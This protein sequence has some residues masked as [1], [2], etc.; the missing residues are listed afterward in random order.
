MDKY[1]ISEPCECKREHRADIDE[2]IIGKG[3]VR[4]VGEVVKSY[5][6]SKPFVLADVNTFE[7]AGKEVCAVLEEK[8][9]PY[10][11]YV[12]ADEALKPDEKAVGSSVLH[13]DYSCD[14]IIAVG[15][16][17]IN[18][19]GKILSRISGRKYIIAATAPS[20]DGYASGTSSIDRDGFKLS[21][22]S[23]CADVIIGDVDILKNAPLHMLKS[24][25]GDM[26]A[27]YISIAE[28]RIGHLVTGEY[29]CER[30]A[31]LVRDALKKCTDNALGLLKRDD[32]AVEAVFE[33][34]V[35]S[36]LAMA[37][38]GISRPASGVEHYFSHVWDMR[39]LE[40]STS[41]DLHGIQCAMG[42][43]R[44][45]KLYESLKQITP[46][47]EKALKYVKNFDYDAWKIQLESFF[48]KGARAMIEQEKT[49][50][51]YS[52]AAHRKRLEKIIDNWDEILKIL[53]EELPSFEQLDELMTALDMPKEFMSIGVDEEAAKLTFLA[54]K[55]IRDKYILSRLA[56]DLG[57]IEELN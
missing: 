5:N 44:A 27:K 57:V 4:Q 19:I 29:Y 1:K 11:K 26:I 53:D 50:Q 34:L 18:D 24:G 31:Q 36:G 39:S 48:G 54:T 30:I 55:D 28:W 45:V 6:C 17:V 40:F 14:I 20:V 47:R 43:R 3:V 41:V 37:Y 10:V 42:S 46:D 38:A 23:R 22:D 15:S 8:G 52:K 7:A 9:I 32:A 2:I 35:I 51:K 13:F 21:L 12:F 56:W 25:L 16:G 33:G 49:E